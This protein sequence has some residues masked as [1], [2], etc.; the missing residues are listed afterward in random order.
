MDDIQRLA[1]GVVAN[2]EKVIVGKHAEVQLALVALHLPGARADRGR[3]GR[4]QDH[5]GQGAG[6]VGGLHLQA[7]AV[8]AGP[9]AQ[10]HHRRLHLQPEDAGVRVPPRAGH[11]ADPA[12]RRDQPRHAQDP[13]RA[14]GGHGGAAGDRGRRHP[15]RCRG[16]SWCWPP[17]TPSSTKAPFPLPEAQLDRFLLRITLGYPSAADEITIMDRQQFVHPIEDTC[18][19]VEAKELAMLQ[20]AVKRVYV[21]PPSRSTSW[22][23]CRPPAC[24]PM[25]TWA[26]AREAASRSSAPARPGPPSRGATS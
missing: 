8:H 13:E 25:C 9:A 2:V 22:P 19:V 23:S 16:R 10:R 1:E 14:A 20:D 24:T 18:Q 5:A 15:R 26:P 12:G 4:G 7:H 6:P 11:H 21:D 3:A 17:R